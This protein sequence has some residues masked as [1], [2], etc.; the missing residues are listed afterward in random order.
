MTEN[1]II[2]IIGELPEE[3]SYA[4]SLALEALNSTLQDYY[5]KKEKEE[6]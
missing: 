5:K 1:N 4:T 3:K 6:K 2:E